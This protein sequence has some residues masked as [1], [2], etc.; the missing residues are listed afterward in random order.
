MQPPLGKKGDSQG[1]NGTQDVAQQ[2]GD[3]T[4]W[5]QTPWPISINFP[6]K[7]VHRKLDGVQYIK[8]KDRPEGIYG[9][10]SSEFH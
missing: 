6:R 7:S 3:G 9:S 2:R 5:P 4:L 8:H 1:A 10:L